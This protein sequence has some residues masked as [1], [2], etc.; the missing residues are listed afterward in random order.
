MVWGRRLEQTLGWDCRY[1]RTLGVQGVQRFQGLAQKA[2][3]KSALC[4]GALMLLA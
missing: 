1:I 4:V 2:R 3:D